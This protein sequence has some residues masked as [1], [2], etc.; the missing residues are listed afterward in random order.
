MK[1]KQSMTE[2]YINSLMS[3]FFRASSVSSSGTSFAR[4][5]SSILIFESLSF[6]AKSSFFKLQIFWKSENTFPSTT[7]FFPRAFDALTPGGRDV[8]SS[9]PQAL[10]SSSHFLFLDCF[11]FWLWRVHTTS[12]QREAPSTHAQG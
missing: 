8:N 2:S 6:I 10:F 9:S 3:F 11:H 5:N 1:V 7:G 12:D 4:I